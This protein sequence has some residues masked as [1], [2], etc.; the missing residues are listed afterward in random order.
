VHLDPADPAEESD[1]VIHIRIHTDEYPKEISF[2]LWRRKQS[3][4]RPVM[5]VRDGEHSS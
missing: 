5:H 4:D 2:K 3:A 1:Y